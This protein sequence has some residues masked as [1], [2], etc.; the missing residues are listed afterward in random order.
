[1]R[2]EQRVFTRVPFRHSVR[3]TDAHG[4][5]GACA[6][7]DVSRGG[8]SVTLERY[9][10]PGPVVQF[11]FDEVL[12]KGEPV[13]FPALVTWCQPERSNPSRFQAGFRV[14]H[15]EPDTLCAVSEVFYRALAQ[16]TEPNIGTP[17]AC[18]G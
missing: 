14:V 11:Q 3:W 15:G 6:V 16:T 5:G 12:Y 18:C 10:R 4:E 13:S 17:T 9:L 8:L 7:R 2:K 1:M